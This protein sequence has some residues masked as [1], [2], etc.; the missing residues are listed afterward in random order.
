MRR[1]LFIGRF[2]PFHIGHLSVLQTMDQD[3][4]I[5]E[6]IIM[7]G[8]ADKSG[9]FDNPF[10]FEK[11][12]EMIRSIL[13]KKPFQIIALP[14]GQ[15]HDKWFENL[16]SELPEFS[17]VYTGSD[18]IKKLFS[19]FIIKTPSIKYKISGTEIRVQIRKGQ[20]WQKWVSKEVAKIISRSMLF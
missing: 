4:E 18:S 2:Q 3:N 16:M 6:I 10:S 12:A 7:I 14:D 17:V 15:N 9:T 5:D 11:R 1:G 19:N 8:S 13:I 20:N